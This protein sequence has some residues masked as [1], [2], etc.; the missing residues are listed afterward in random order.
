[1]K[2]NLMNSAHKTS[3]H[4]YRTN[5][6]RIFGGRASDH[7]PCS[8]CKHLDACLNYAQVGS[9]AWNRW[10]TCDDP[11]SNWEAK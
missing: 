4:E 5:W 8:S 6:E 11:N 10:F 3:T 1:M 2:E 9:E 7:K